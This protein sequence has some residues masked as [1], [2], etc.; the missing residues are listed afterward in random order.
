M[1][2]IFKQYGGIVN[3]T[4]Y[5]DSLL[6]V[7]EIAVYA[8]YA[9]Q[10]IFGLVA[11]ENNSGYGKRADTDGEFRIILPKIQQTQCIERISLILP[12]WNFIFML[13]MQICSRRTVELHE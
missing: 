3:Q 6:T 8:V 2:L 5:K 7:N 4:K 1:V 12:L 13:Q 11:F 10:N 9:Q